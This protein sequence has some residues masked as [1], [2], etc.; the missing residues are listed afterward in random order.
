M[1]PSSMRAIAA[2][3]RG[4]PSVITAMTLPAP[5]PPQN[6]DLLVRVHATS[7]NPVDT[8]IRA[9]TYDDYQASGDALAYYARSPGLPQVLGYDGAG[10]VEAAG[11]AAAAAGW[12]AGDAVFYSGAPDRPGADAELQ[13]V[14]ARSAARKP[15]RLDWTEAAAMP[16]T[17]I[18]AW[19]ALVERMAIAE[20]E[21]AGILIVNGAGGVGSVAS[22]IARHVLRLPAVVTTASR[23]E[24]RAFSLERGATH[25]VNHHGDLPAQVR[26]LALPVPIKYVFITHRTEQYIG[27]AAAIAAPFGKVCSIVQTEELPMYGTEWMA[28]GL[29]FVWEL[30][31]TKPWYGVELDSHGKILEK[32]RGLVDEGIV[33]SHLQKRLPLT[34]EGVRKGHELLAAGKV[35]GKVGLG[36]EEGGLA[37][38]EAF[39]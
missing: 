11:P 2:T 3:A 7:V 10:V 24:T 14:D 18:T 9:G 25:T 32:L 6:H 15:A 27:P 23:A 29:T 33:K 16:L 1:P 30:I 34:A 26:G 12:Q 20:G 13:A 36:V 21:H 22:Q 28:K 31:G 35:I 39:S 37:A 38:G 17:W 5:P 19:E 4:D 8:K